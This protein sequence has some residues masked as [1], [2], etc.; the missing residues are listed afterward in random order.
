[1]SPRSQLLAELRKFIAEMCAMCLY[2]GETHT[3]V[4]LLAKVKVLPGDNKFNTPFQHSAASTLL[5]YWQ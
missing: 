1:M 3:Q 4:L 5:N 2:F